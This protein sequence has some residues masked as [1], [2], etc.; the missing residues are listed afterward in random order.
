MNIILCACEIDKAEPCPINMHTRITVLRGEN[1]AESDTVRA[2]FVRTSEALQHLAL[3][4]QGHHVGMTS[5]T[6]GFARFIGHHCPLYAACLKHLHISHSM[7]QPHLQ[8]S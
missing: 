4:P 6:V 8:S 5:G 2:C 3:V 1:Q 7:N